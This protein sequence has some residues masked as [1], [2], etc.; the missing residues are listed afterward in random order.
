MPEPTFL[1]DQA[2]APQ[3]EFGENGVV[4]IVNRDGD[5]KAAQ[6]LAPKLN[7]A[8]GF[9]L[10][11]GG[12]NPY[13]TI[14]LGAA[15]GWPAT[16]SPCSLPTKVE[17]PSNDGNF[18]FMDFDSTADEI[19]Q[20]TLF[21]PRNYDGSALKAKFLWTANSASTNSVVWTIQ[22]AAFGDGTSIDTAW[23]TLKQVTDAN[24]SAAYKLNISEFTPEFVLGGTPAGGHLTQIR[25][26]RDPTNGA[27]TLAVDARLIA[28]S[29]LYRIG[30]YGD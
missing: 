19:A 16:T 24:H 6:R 30:K 21:M 22:G 4:P 18:V 13:R 20:W 3:D 8:K 7:L 15:G 11:E 25:V 2:D 23:G 10:S 14:I 12:I 27:D 26:Y 28:V 9:Q 5:F 1:Q 29:I 17:F